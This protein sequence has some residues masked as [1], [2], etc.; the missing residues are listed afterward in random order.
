ML[1]FIVFT[2]V[3]LCVI[4]VVLAES[5][6]RLCFIVIQNWMIYVIRE[7]LVCA[8]FGLVSLLLFDITEINCALSILCTE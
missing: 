1:H 5:L 2:R 3:C 6:L 4:F 7:E 8:K